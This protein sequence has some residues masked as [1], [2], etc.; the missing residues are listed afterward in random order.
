MKHRPDC[1]IQLADGRTL[2]FSRFGRSSAVPILLFH[3]TPGSRCFGFPAGTPLDD[4]R[5]Q[6]ILPE[7]P[8]YGLSSA[9]PDRTV[10]NWADDIR[11]LIDTLGFENVHLLGL[12]GG[13]PFALA[14]A[15]QIPE[16]VLSVNLVAS[17]APLYLSQLRKEMAAV[18]KLAYYAARFVPRAIQLNFLFNRYSLYHRPTVYLEKL[19][20]QLSDWD[21]ALL[22]D[23]VT[24]ALFLK[25]MR[26]A[27]RN[28]IKG[29]I[30]DIQL[31]MKPWGFT[32]SE[33]TGPV[34]LW[35]GELDTLIPASMGRYL[36]AQLTNCQSD[37]ISNAG[38]LLFLDQHYMN[39]ILSAICQ[40]SS[41]SMVCAAHAVDDA[42]NPC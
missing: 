13:G 27:Y 5:V 14:C 32:L 2:S 23:P 4:G 35:Q 25:H 17:A 28:G 24:Q 15:H 8:G 11:Q 30:S 36:S 9:K 1:T 16:R 3:G 12:S 33:I 21:E 26:E 39:T 10:L 38:H 34:R 20:T 18:N 41:D 7:R 19:F 37:F 22:R 42:L 31:L 40:D 6:V 29:A